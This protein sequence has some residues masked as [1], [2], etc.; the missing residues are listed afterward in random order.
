MARHNGQWKHH[1]VLP[2][3]RHYIDGKLI[4]YL[5]KGPYSVGDEALQELQ[6]SQ[7]DKQE[8]RLYFKCLG[9]KDKDKFMGDL[10]HD[11]RFDKTG[12]D[13]TVQG[14]ISKY[15]K[16]KTLHSSGQE[17]LLSPT[18]RTSGLSKVGK[19]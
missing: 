8:F 7:A 6:F 3:R 18:Y 12:E 14:R 2:D 9:A 11:N 16:N 17:A 1:Y 10:L 4:E 5:D 19:Y 15:S 13:K